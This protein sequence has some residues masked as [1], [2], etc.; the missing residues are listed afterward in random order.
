MPFQVIRDVG[1]DMDS[2]VEW[3]FFDVQTALFR[4]AKANHITLDMS[5][6]EGLEEGLLYNLD[7]IVH[8]KK[9][10]IKCPHC[11]SMNTARYI[12]G[13]L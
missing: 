6:H 7:F 5:K 12:Y 10:Q 4:E 8:N 11:G 13:Y 2:F 9:A 1:Y 3:G